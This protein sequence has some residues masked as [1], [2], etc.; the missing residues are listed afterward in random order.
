MKLGRN[1]RKDRP[2]ISYTMWEIL[3]L[4]IIERIMEKAWIIF[5]LIDGQSPSICAF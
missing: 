4:Q 1:S 2:M 3:R 5:V